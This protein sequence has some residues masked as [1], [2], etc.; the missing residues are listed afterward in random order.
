MM[1]E[2]TKFKGR[3]NKTIGDNALREYLSDKEETSNS[4]QVLGNEKLV[5]FKS[6]LDSKPKVL[7]VGTCITIPK[8]MQKR[9][10]PPLGICYVAAML[11]KDNFPVSIF[12][13]CV[14][15]WEHERESE[16]LVTY[17]LPPDDE[18]FKEMLR[19]GEYDVV[20]LSVVFSTDLVNLLETAKVIK[21]ILPNTT[22]VVGGLHPTIYP[23]DI[24]KSDKV[25]RTIDFVIRGEGEYRFSQFLKYLEVGKIDLNSDGLVGYYNN[26]LFINPQVSTIENLDELPFP[27]FHLLPIEKY[28]KINVP[29]SP[30]PQGDRVLP[31]LTTRGCPI[32]CSFCSN[33]NTWRKHR[34]RSPQNI[35]DEIEYLKSKFN[36]DEIQFA[37]DNLT[38][39]MKGSM[40]KFEKIK[41][42]DV[43]WCTPNGTMINKLSPDLLQTM[44][45][46]GMY[47]ITL[48]IDSAN[49]RTLKEL[50][51]KPMN[52][53]SVPGLINKARELGVF[54]HGTLVVGMPGETIE[55]IENGFEY[56]KNNLELTSISVFIASAIPGSEL[57]HDMLDQGKITEEEAKKIDT[58]KISVNISDINPSILEESI[59]EFQTEFLEIIK[60]K[61]PDEYKRKYNKF[62]QSKSWDELQC[63]GKLT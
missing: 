8:Y 53:N 58:S 40:E 22:I 35:Y 50:H 28:F 14:E 57:Y 43:L 7:L 17:G 39:D 61:Y 6:P 16:N 48:S 4:P 36:I 9:C 47:Q 60:E 38:Y 19:V 11:E 15:D 21:S 29:F 37:D 33:T 55:E 27:A 46:S 63:G 24:F 41:P 56:V 59:E 12:D 25:N 26:K 62:I 13:C 32:G 51:H 44:F 34:A 23:Q 10:I 3:S 54:T 2:S 31:M 30:V 18:R 1:E 5:D 52:I 49:E 42:L 20:G 45:D